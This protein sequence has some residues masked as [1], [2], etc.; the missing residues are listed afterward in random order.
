M[1]ECEI[2]QLSEGILDKINELER[3][4]KNQTDRDIVLVAYETHQTER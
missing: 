1:Q 3:Q 2:A 4:I